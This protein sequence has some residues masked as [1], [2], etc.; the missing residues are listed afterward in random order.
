[1]CDFRVVLQQSGNEEVI[2]ENVTQLQ[3]EP[4]GIAVSSLFEGPRT[5]PA[6]LVRSIDFLAGKVYLEKRA[7]A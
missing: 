3:V 4:D 5:V 6:A 7:A 1:M 2:M